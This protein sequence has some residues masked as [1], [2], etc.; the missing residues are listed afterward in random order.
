MDTLRATVFGDPKLYGL[1]KML[2]M[3]QLEN[4]Y[5]YICYFV[6]VSYSLAEFP[7]IFF[8]LSNLLSTIAGFYRTFLR[9]FPTHLVSRNL[10]TTKEVLLINRCGL[11]VRLT[12]QFTKTFLCMSDP[13]ACELT[14]DTIRCKR[15]RNIDKRRHKNRYVFISFRF[16]EH[17]SLASNR[18]VYS[19]PMGKE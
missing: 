12:A 5:S 1:S 9:T 18:F 4:G 2:H 16:V 15:F 17:L 8:V 6:S 13:V 14:T 11:K 19:L 7:R 10:C 3:N